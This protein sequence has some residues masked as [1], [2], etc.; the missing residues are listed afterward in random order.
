MSDTKAGWKVQPMSQ[1]RLD[2]LSWPER[3]AYEL[4]VLQSWE[5][6]SNNHWSGM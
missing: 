5:K 2:R 4:E 3:E 6:N 1:E